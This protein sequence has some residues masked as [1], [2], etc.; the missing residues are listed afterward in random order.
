MNPVIGLDVFKG[1][2]MAQAFLDK[3]RPRGKVFRFKH[4]NK[5]LA[6]FRDYMKELEDEA[7]I[8]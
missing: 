1:E 6:R 3:G 7:G 8:V 5:A 4:T 2:S